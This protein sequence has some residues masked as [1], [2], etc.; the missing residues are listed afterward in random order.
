MPRHIRIGVAEDF[1][2]DVDRHPIFDSEAGE[3]VSGYMRRQVLV[4]VADHG[5]FLQV[6]VHLL[7]ARHGQ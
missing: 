1:G 2:D 5:Q 6:T 3:C 7:V 4:D